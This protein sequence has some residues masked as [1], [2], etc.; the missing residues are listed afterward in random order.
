MLRNTAFTHVQTH[1]LAVGAAILK[2]DPAEHHLRH[3]LRTLNIRLFSIP[4]V[5]YDLLRL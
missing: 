2:W 1:V 5:L 3:A 4:W